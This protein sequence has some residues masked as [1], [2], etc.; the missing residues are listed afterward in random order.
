MS[1]DDAVRARLARQLT[2]AVEHLWAVLA[3][4][5]RHRLGWSLTREETEQADAAR[6]FVQGQPSG[7]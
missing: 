5:D 4:L 1:A 2:E 7:T 3:I 6:R